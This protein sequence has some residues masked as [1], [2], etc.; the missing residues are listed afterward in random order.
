MRSGP[1]E[2]AGLA[3]LPPQDQPW[4]D[5]LGSGPAHAPHEVADAVAA[6]LGADVPRQLPPGLPDVTD[7]RSRL[8]L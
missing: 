3:G 4:E 5:L 7:L 6:S 1:P 2:P 8:D